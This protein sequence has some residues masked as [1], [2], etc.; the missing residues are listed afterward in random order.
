M[1]SFARSR[2]SILPA[3]AFATGTGLL[4]VSVANAL[5]RATDSTSP[6]LAW[7][8][9]VVFALPIFYRLTSREATTGERLALVCMFG[10]GLYAVKILRDAP[11]FTFSDE[12]V[13]AYNA[14]QIAVHDH[15]FRSNP[16]LEVTPS[17]P[18]LEGATSALMKLTG[19]SS[20]VCGLILIGAA[21]LLLLVSLFALFDRVGGSA[22]AA[23][24]GV[25]IYSGNFNFLYWGAQFS[26]ESLAL[27][28]LLMVLMA[29][30]ER[31]AA[32][33]QALRSWGLPV[34][35]GI[36]AIVATHH[37]TSYATAAVIAALAIACWC[38]RRTWKP[39]NPWRFAVFAAVLALAWLVLAAGSTIDYLSPV[40]SNAIKAIGNTISGEQPPRGLFQGT[41]SNIPATP[42]AAKALAFL[43]VAALAAG[44]PFGL[45]HFWRGQ[46]RRP[47]AILFAIASVAFFG[48]LALRL[49]PPA[50]ETGNRA[51]EFLFVGLAFVLSWTLLDAFRR[52]R[53]RAWVR[54]GAA[55]AIALVVIGG[56]ISG[57][58][59]DSQLAKPLRISA[60]GKTL[61]SPPLSMAEWAASHVDGGR[62]AAATGDAGF[63]LDPGDKFVKAGSSPDVEDLLEAENL[64]PWQLP[65]LR[66]EKLGYV[67]ADRRDVGADTLRAY[68]FSPKGDEEALLPRSTTRKFNQ[69]PHVSRLYSNGDI[70]VYGIGE[71]P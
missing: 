5:S 46:R 21:R 19:A 11:V 59:W 30:A 42:P 44:L 37:L 10:M 57:W 18:G 61:P 35:L 51:S 58:P 54:L 33:R 43:A 24:L 70:S 40:L 7:L 16:I 17:Y 3:A 60:E 36:M 56:A 71:K 22:R 67:V 68:Y 41:S 32:P 9:I 31:E 34:A 27:P 15:I 63:L 50:W 12:L 45:I 25:A 20:Y 29:L 49:A 8:G 65:L 69:I 52:L 4:I 64:Q 53:D 55:A 28:L 47:F 39:P 13:H 1:R 6:A 26:Y 48:T 2:E 14:H 23:G 62:F 66:E 38:V